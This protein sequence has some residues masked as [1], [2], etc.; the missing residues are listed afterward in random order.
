MD[1]SP[2]GK[3]SAELRNEI[4]GLALSFED[5]IHIRYT[6]DIP[7]E[8][9]ERF[10]SDIRLESTEPRA[11]A[12]LQT[13]RQIHSEAT[14]MFYANNAFSLELP[15]VLCIGKIDVSS[16]IVAF[17]QFSQPI[18]DMIKHICVDV[19]YHQ[20]LACMSVTIA[21]LK[22]VNSQIDELR[23][24]AR[25]LHVESFKCNLILKPYIAQERKRFD[26]QLDMSNYVS[27]RKNAIAGLL[28]E[29]KIFAAYG[30]PVPHR[31]RFPSWFLR[32]LEEY[33]GM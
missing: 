2:L 9:K 24:I 14:A 8:S 29:R 21:E 33:E 25:S 5:T 12:F 20:L 7:L 16:G 19:E 1:S 3:L 17:Q 30:K 11:T 22:Q 18:G 28:E 26:V 32:R 23:G 31:I 4:Y 15:D 13:C 6:S 10:K 27:S